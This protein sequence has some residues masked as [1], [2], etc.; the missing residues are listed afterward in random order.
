MEIVHKTTTITKIVNQFCKSSIRNKD[1][2]QRKK[3]QIGKRPK[4]TNAKSALSI[5][6][7]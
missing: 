7:K 1:T 5:W 2:Q 3:T 4:A 6:L